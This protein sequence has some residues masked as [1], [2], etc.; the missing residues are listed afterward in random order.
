MSPVTAAIMRV[1]LQHV[2]QNYPLAF[3]PE[4]LEVYRQG[5]PETPL[6]ECED[7]GFGLPRNFTECPLCQGRVGLGLHSK[8]KAATAK[9]N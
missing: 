7:C 2:Y 8:K 6:F 9:W 4:V 3:P 1:I 5:M